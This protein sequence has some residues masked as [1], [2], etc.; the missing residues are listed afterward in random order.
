MPFIIIS[1]Y[2]TRDQVLE[3]GANDFLKKPFKPSELK[4]SVKRILEANEGQD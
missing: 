3:A 2:A 4:D 1:G